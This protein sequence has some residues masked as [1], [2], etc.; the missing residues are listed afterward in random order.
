LENRNFERFFESEES[1]RWCW[2]SIGNYPENREEVAHQK[3]QI[4]GGNHRS[5]FL[6]YFLTSLLLSREN[7]SEIKS[8]GICPLSHAF[9]NCFFRP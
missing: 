3:L 2:E 8:G 5:S 4:S 9:S 1:K 6:P 7:P